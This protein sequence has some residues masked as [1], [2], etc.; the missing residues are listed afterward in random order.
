[1]SSTPGSGRRNNGSFAHSGTGSGRSV[2]E[3][4]GWSAEAVETWRFEG[5]WRGGR[6]AFARRC[7]LGRSL[8]L[9]I[10][11]GGHKLICTELG[12]RAAGSG[13]W[14]RLQLWD[15]MVFCALCVLSGQNARSRSSAGAAQRRF[16][17]LGSARG[18]SAQY[19]AS[20]SARSAP[21]RALYTGVA[22]DGRLGDMEKPSCPTYPSFAVGTNGSRRISKRFC[23]VISS[24]LSN[25]SQATQTTKLVGLASTF[26]I[27]RQ[28]TKETQKRQLE[29]KE[30]NKRTAK[31]ALPMEQRAGRGR[32]WKP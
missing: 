20:S 25:R 14:M 27:D 23:F 26:D 1:V 11:L 6:G 24:I 28:A 18:T 12:G 3:G 8:G 4:S 30:G 19:D 16:E 15:V 21:A 10:P 22:N 31:P 7:F 29:T 9:A 32:E 5:E 17:V 13:F 2:V